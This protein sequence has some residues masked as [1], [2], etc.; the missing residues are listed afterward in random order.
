MAHA[1]RLRIEPGSLLLAWPDLVDPNFMHRVILMCRHSDQGAFGLVLNDPLEVGTETLLAS[2]SVLGTVEFPI[3][4]GG[5]V[6]VG[7]LQYLHRVPEAI[8]E[9]QQVTDELWIGGD[10]DALASFIAR[11]TERALGEV[12]LFL[13]YSGWGAGQLEGEL[14]GGSWV[15]AAADTGEVFSSDPDG[16]WKRILRGLGDVGRDLSN[17]PPDPHWN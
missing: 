6:D 15:P 11:D 12:R 9:A 14:T 7:T 16:A 4:R 10:F 13:G 5:P 8:P 2:H 1:D 17:Q 3:F